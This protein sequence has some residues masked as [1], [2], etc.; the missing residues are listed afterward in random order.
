[1]N[2][3]FRKR[4]RQNDP[5]KLFHFKIVFS[6]W[7]SKFESL[8]VWISNW[9]P[10]WTGSNLGPDCRTFMTFWSFQRFSTNSPPT[11]SAGRLEFGHVLDR[12]IFNLNFGFCYQA[13]IRLLSG[14]YQDCYQDS[15]F[16]RPPEKH[17]GLM[18]IS[19][20]A[21]IEAN[22]KR[23]GLILPQNPKNLI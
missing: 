20:V 9:H 19:L 15:W 16:R 2:D 5:V 4:T 14:C 10:H 8:K 13:A 22:E 3:F 1:M 6:R 12:S 7:L 17:D 23:S 21:R 18:S 11:V